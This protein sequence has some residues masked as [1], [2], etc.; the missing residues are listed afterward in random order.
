MEIILQSGISFVIA[1]QALGGWLT[2]PMQFFT[3]LG[4]QEFL[5]LILPVVYW[6]VNAK[7]GARIG[8][9]MLLTNTINDVFKL[10]L[11]GPRPYW[12]STQVKATVFEPS[13]GAPSNHTQV[14]VA[15]WGTFASYIKRPWAWGVAIGLMLL[16][17][18]SR[19]YLGVHFPHDVLLGWLLGALVLW[20]VLRW[21]DALTAWLK[22][23]SLK[24]QIGLAFG[25]SMLMTAASVAAFL[26][27]QN[28]VLPVEWIENV[29]KAGFSETL[30]PAS[31]DYTFT[32]TGAM[33]GFLAGL[34]WIHAV[35]GFS[36]EG[37]IKLRMIRYVVGLLVVL[38][39][40]Y[41]LGAIFPRDASV[42]AYI[43]RYLR[44]ALV[45]CWITAGAPL[46]FLRFHLAEKA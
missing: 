25:L 3:F 40:W 32:G 5:L 33:F 11:H 21:S 9:A 29:R 15:I 31:L 17:G 44:Y 46:V 1:F 14:A 7:M 12:V 16:I 37:P 39:L 26:S 4:S 43:L 18:L 22:A 19:I 10:A 6:S 30:A 13:F 41:G 27:L 42:L 38:I 2:L 28:W 23:Q 45:G 20:G 24:K 8:M 34:A 36:A 35:G